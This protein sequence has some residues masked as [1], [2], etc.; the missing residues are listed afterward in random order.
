[1]IIK[2]TGQVPV[3]ITGISFDDNLD[4]YNNTRKLKSAVNA[5][6]V[7][8]QYLQSDF[9][10]EYDKNVT[11]HIEFCSKKKPQKVYYD[12]F[13]VNFGQFKDL[14]W[15]DARPPYNVK[16]QDINQVILNA[17]LMISKRKI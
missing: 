9:D 17:A 1:M 7:P 3:Q 11:V 14:L 5:W 6:I 10:P 15:T 2:N 8:G 16:S 12:D 13:K 4:A